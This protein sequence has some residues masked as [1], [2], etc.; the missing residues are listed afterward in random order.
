M[1]MTSFIV[2]IICLYQ[3]PVI[4]ISQI[5]QF[6]YFIKFQTYSNAKILLLIIFPVYLYKFNVWWLFCLKNI[7]GCNEVIAR[8]ASNYVWVIFKFAI[9]VRS[10]KFSIYFNSTEHMQNTN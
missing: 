8:S 10:M 6:L 7:Y 4:I 3:F 5:A 9:A 2:P 1:L